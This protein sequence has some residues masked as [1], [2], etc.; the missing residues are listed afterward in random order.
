M[1][2][3]IY[4]GS[5][6]P[7]HLGHESAVSTV[8]SELRPDRIIIMPDCIAPH[9]AMAENTPAPEHRL[10][11]CR[12]AFGGIPGIEVSDLEIRRGGRSYTVDTLE[13]LTALYPDDLFYLVIGSDMLVSFTTGWYRFEDILR[14]CSLTVISRERDDMDELEHN[15]AR[16]RNVYGAEV[17]ILKNHRPVLM[18]SSQVRKSIRD[19][20]VSDMLNAAVSEYIKKNGLYI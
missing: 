6:N 4:G 15:A 19:N 2:T 13:Q 20:G 8:A 11:M 10:E 18:S 7:P 3:A 5:F 9:K 16:L 14:M 1:K 12:L 17:I